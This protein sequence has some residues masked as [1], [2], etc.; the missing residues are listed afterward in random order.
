[1]NKAM[2]FPLR[3]PQYNNPMPKKKWPSA[4]ILGIETSCDETAI[5][6]VEDGRQ[7]LSNI[8]AS[9]E[10]LHAQY[11]GIFPEV[12]SRE[13]VKV[14]DAV[15]ESALKEAHLE[16]NDIDAIAVTSGPGLPGSL[17][18]GLNLAK[19]LSL[20]SRKPLY[21]INHLEG[22]LYSAWVNLE[23]GEA[24]APP[25]FPLLALIV[26]GG[27]TE[28]VIMHDHLKYERLGGT[29]DD[30]AGEAFDKV[31]R[32]LELG[33][34]G[35]PAIQKAAQDGDPEAIKF[36]RAWLRDTWDFSF[37]GLKTAV[38]HKVKDLAGERSIQDANL[39][40]NDIAASFQAAVVDVL[41][42]KSK[43]AAEEYEVKNVLVAGGV[44]ANQALREAVQSA[45]DLP[46][47][48]PPLELCTDNA[49]M[50]AAAGYYRFALDKPAS[51]DI[52]VFPSWRLSP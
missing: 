31:A 14:I 39:P 22:H 29:L 35:G 20:G 8:V 21:A 16:I 25:E 15:L 7:A 51:L 37:S 6:V 49:A 5:S 26:S 44:S 42:G 41:V 38:L 27:H 43:A 23:D 36:P 11:G 9:Q 24:P 33:Y 18:V 10:A 46:V 32:L 47:F 12:A 17:V 3:P 1:M 34:P 19:G 48:L 13:H 40:I 2:T 52:D 28:L 4:R 30:A 50:I 45:I